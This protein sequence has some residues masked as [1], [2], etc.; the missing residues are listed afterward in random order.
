MNNLT[1]WIDDE[2]VTSD[3]KVDVLN[4]YT[5]EVFAT[6]PE[7]THNQVDKAVKA[8]KKSQEVEFSPYER[9]EVLRKVAELLEERVDDFAEVMTQEVG[10]TLKECKG[11][12]TRSVQ[13]LLISAEEAKR[14]HGEG[15]PVES[16]PGSE[17][18][19]AFTIRVP[20]GVV[21]AITPFNVP[22]NLVCHKIGPAIAAGNSVILKP[23]EKT[24]VVALKLAEL[25]RE[26]GLLKNRLQVVTGWGHTVGEYM[27]D[28]QGIDMYTFTG[29]KKV[30]EQI[31]K[32]AGMRKVSLELGNNSATIIHDD[33][34]LNKASDLVAARGYNNAGQVCISV[35]RVYVHE[36]KYNEFSSLLKEKVDALNLGDP[37]DEQTD[38]GPMISE[39]AAKTVK[40]WVDEAVSEGAELITGGEQNGALFKPTLLGYVTPNMRVC[41]EEVFGPV[42]SLI[43]YSNFDEVLDQVNDS[44]YGLQAGLFTTN[45]NLAMKAARKIEVGGLIINDTSAYR[46]DQMPYGGVKSSGNGKEGPK[47]AI[48]E[49]TEERLVVFNL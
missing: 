34:D 15:V 48:E 2:Q 9:Y 47:Y 24:P 11:E 7:A 22:L 49:M 25:F 32:K 26:A 16:A 20:V 28:H 10:K 35:Q 17:N 1:M 13:T 27:L 36:S 23:G 19:M 37:F 39:E 14:I 38:V 21:A 44:E 40:E 42:V 5:Q 3:E 8:A 45:L 12:V 41:R 31:K 30:G 6:I 46:V 29:S 33:A 18:R 43:P 4:K